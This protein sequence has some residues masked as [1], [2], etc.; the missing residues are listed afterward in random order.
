MDAERIRVNGAAAAVAFAVAFVAAACGGSDGP[1]AEEPAP[2]SEES[3]RVA[4]VPEHRWVE[5]QHLF[6]RRRAMVSRCF[7]TAIDAGE[8]T[9]D[10]R[11]YVTI[12]LQIDEQGR[13][14]NAR[15][16]ESTLDSQHL[17]GCILD[18]V[19]KWE[20]G[21]LPRTIEYSYSY[22]FETL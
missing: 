7:S 5:I 12:M 9:D 15:V 22:Q 13:A 10:D 2:P 11:G 20:F 6:D 3:D 14:Q 4:M 17:H 19:R 21:S 16:E 1:G 18:H 8:L